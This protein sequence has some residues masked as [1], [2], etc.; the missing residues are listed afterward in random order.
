ML[1]HRD[2]R[3]RTS[4]T[5]HATLDAGHQSLHTRPSTKDISHSTCHAAPIIHHV[6]QSKRNLMGFKLVKSQLTKP[7][8]AARTESS[9]YSGPA[10]RQTNTALSF[11]H[12]PGPGSKPKQYSI[13]LFIALG[14][15][16]SQSSTAYDSLLPWAG[17]EAK[18]IQHTTLY[19]PGPGSKPKPSLLGLLG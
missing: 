6:G 8:I 1:S 16:R 13:L 10:R 7:N 18:A 3:R 12:C 11:F 4:V 15:A 9:L 2:P 19:C 14:R 17:L 5:P